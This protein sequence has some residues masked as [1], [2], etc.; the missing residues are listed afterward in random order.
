[1]IKNSPKSKMRKAVHKSTKNK[2]L[3][4]TCK[5][6]GE[7]LF[8]KNHREVRPKKG[9]TVGTPGSWVRTNMI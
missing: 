2:T 3:T 5:Q 7:D 1:M 6:R 4:Y 9:R 8:A